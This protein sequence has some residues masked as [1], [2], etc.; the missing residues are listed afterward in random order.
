[1]YTLLMLCNREQL[2]KKITKIILIYFFVVLHHKNSSVGPKGIMQGNWRNL[3]S[4]LKSLSWR[5]SV[6][7]WTDRS[8]LE[9]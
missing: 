5:H 9:Q 7:V 3:F 8:L 6:E 1:M 4:D 2:I